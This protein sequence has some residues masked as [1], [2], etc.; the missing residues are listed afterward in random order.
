MTYPT[1]LLWSFESV[2]KALHCVLQMGMAEQRQGWEI[3]SDKG[4]SMGIFSLVG[5]SVKSS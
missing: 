3:I 4:Q 1:F 2:P 5:Y